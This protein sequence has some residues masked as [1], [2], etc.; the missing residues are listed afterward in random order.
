[1]CSYGSEYIIE[2]SKFPSQSHDLEIDIFDV[3]LKAVNI[4]KNDNAEILSVLSTKVIDHL[5][6]HNCIIYFYCDQQ[7]IKKSKQNK[8]LSNKEFRHKLF[9]ALFER[10]KSLNVNSFDLLIENIIIEDKENDN[11]Y[12]SLLAKKSDEAILQ[13]S[14]LMIES[15]NQK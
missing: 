4:I 11:H 15:L 8:H 2:I 14:M 1:V 3:T 9:N 7:P 5:N 6:T 12:I 10:T 13:D